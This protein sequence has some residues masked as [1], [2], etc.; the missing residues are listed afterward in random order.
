MGLT[1]PLSG[2]SGEMRAIEA[3]LRAPDVSGVVLQ[4][5]TGVGRTRIARQVVSAARAR[6]V[7]ARWVVGAASATAVPLGALAAWAPPDAADTVHLLRGVIEAL[8]AAPPGVEVLV[9]VDDAHLLDDLSAFVLHQ[10]VARGTAKLLLTLVEGGPVPAAVRDV[11]TSGQFDRVAVAPL[12]A[13]P[14]QALVEAALG[15]TVDPD[16]SRRLWELTRGNIL[17]LRMMVEHAVADGG[18]ADQGGRWR[19]V[20]EPEVPPGLAELVEARIGDLPAEV[21]DVL[22]AVTVAEPLD[23]SVLERA[24]DPAAVEQAETRDLITLENAGA[25]VQVRLA[26]PLYGEVRRRRAPATRLRRI[27]GRVATELAARTGPDD[28]RRT[29]RLAALSID[30]DVDLDTGVLVRASRG[31]VSLG[32]LHLAERLAGAADGPDAGVEPRLLRAHALSWLGRGSEADAV[33]ADIPDGGLGGADLGRVAFVRASNMLWALGDPAGARQLIDHVA[34]SAPPSARDCLAAFRAVYWFVM[35]Q[36]DRALEAA[37]GL[38]LH[39]LPEI[40]GTEIA[41]VLTVLA[42]DAGQLERAV[43]LAEAGH[44]VAARSLDAPQMR[45]NIADAHVGA[46]LL[47]G[48]ITEASAVADRVCAE[49]VDLPGAARHVASAVRGRAELA[50]G[51]VD[52]AAVELGRAVEELSASGHATGWGYRYRI[53]HATA[54]AMRGAA[55][56]AADVLAV[57]DRLDRRYRRLGWE[58]SLARAWV[59]AAEGAVSEAVAVLVAAAQDAGRVG[60]FAAEVLCLQTAVQFGDHSCAHRL[61]ELAEIVTGPRVRLAA[62]FADGLRDDDAAELTTVSEGFEEMGD[63]A[64]AVDAAAHAALAHRRADRRG[65]A[66]GCVT[67]AGALAQQCGGLSTPALRAAAEPLPLTDREREIVMLIGAGLSNRAIADRL[68]LSVRT[69]ESHVYKAMSKT[70]TGSREELAALL[71]PHAGSRP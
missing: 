46:L 44:T 70:G 39:R 13:E 51:H 3:A 2:R 49:A 20:G 48:R 45:Y 55:R 19:W 50:A 5:P 61:H 59:I 35:D 8:G 11:V 10:L 18:I 69:V 43:E 71:A 16:T 67:R 42:A 66:L 27:R 17:Y 33:L 52:R 38:E 34:R 1:W 9:C 29:V 41:W 62:R 64:A 58:R 47:A 14:T 60:Q 54:L 28:V 56:E 32:D 26:H 12:G 25:G 40:V 30:S 21:N 57:I 65:S 24:T 7:D 37:T 4:G 36:P 15:G 63:L 22:D 31:A 6:G 23:L 68:T 53:P